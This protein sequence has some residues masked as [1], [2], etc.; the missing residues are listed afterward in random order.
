MTRAKIKAALLLW[1]RRERYR[2]GRHDHWQ[3]IVDH[4]RKAN[5]H[6]RQADIDKRDHW[7]KLL[8]SARAK[9]AEL[10]HELNNGA[11]IGIDLSNNNNSVDFH[12]VYKAGYRFV[13]LK[14]S[15][16]TTFRDGTFLARV[17]AARAAGLRVG[18]Y[19]FVS[20]ASASSQVD[21][22]VSLISKAGLGRGDLLP[23]LD[24]E[25]PG[26]STLLAGQM[27]H[28]LEDRLGV[29]PMIYTFP[30]FARWPST[31]ACKLWIAH[32]GV[33][34]PTIPKPWGKYTAWQ[35]SS[36]AHVPG[37]GGNC[38]V[39]KTPDLGAITW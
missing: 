5:K 1:R 33:S 39:N 11:A 9:I 38:D 12:A 22:F 6:P 2:K 31:F 10:E 35:H 28:Q 3:R 14:A 20:A 8:T 18:A 36:T 27:V 13:W 25:K 16:G 29:K 7:S 21:L 37:V 19:H 17:K 32:F 4:D 34:R 15:E 26:V 24:V 30:A 23:V